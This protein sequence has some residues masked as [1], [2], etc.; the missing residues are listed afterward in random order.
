MTFSQ[1]FLNETTQ[2]A[3]ALGAKILEEMAL[4]LADLRHRGGR[5]FY[6]IWWRGG[7][8]KSCSK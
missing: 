4:A 2:I 6:W 3:E 8:R 7:A 1:S 5:L